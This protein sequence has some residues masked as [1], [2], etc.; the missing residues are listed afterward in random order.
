MISIDLE[1]V[2]VL[3]IVLI[4]LLE[5]LESDKANSIFNY[6]NVVCYFSP[7]KKNIKY[8]HNKRLK[9]EFNLYLSIYL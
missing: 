8:Q 3:T 7:N 1:G 5:A 4:Y 2:N 9:L 6:G